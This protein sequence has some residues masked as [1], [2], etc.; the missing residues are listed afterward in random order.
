MFTLYY[1]AIFS[2][3]GS[4]SKC[5]V[6]SL[7]PAAAT[8]DMCPETKHMARN[9]RRWTC[10]EMSADIAAS[11]NSKG[12]TESRERSPSRVSPKNCGAQTP[13]ADQAGHGEGRSQARVLAT[14]GGKRVGGGGTSAQSPL[15]SYWSKFI[16]ATWQL[17]EPFFW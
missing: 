15:A 14:S 3:A 2:R 11:A 9:A 1:H 7:L 5:P 4:T 13:G 6:V 8:R 16:V 17:R 10:N 12:H